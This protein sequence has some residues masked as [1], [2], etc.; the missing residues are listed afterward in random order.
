MRPG[1][2]CC[3]AAC[4][5]SSSPPGST[6]SSR[7][8]GRSRPRTTGR[9]PTAGD[10]LR[11]TAGS[12][13]GC[14]DAELPAQFADMLTVARSDLAMMRIKGG[15]KAKIAA[16]AATLSERLQVLLGPAVRLVESGLRTAGEY[17]KDVQ[18]LV[19]KLPQAERGNPKLDMALSDVQ[20]T[21]W[22][23]T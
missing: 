2:T 23:T 4:R 18:A 16:R 21:D 17:K 8:W 6:R 9:S 3:A 19:E 7:A 1:T 11:R 14:G 20:L 12:V 22:P 15:S 5:W 13:A 10:A